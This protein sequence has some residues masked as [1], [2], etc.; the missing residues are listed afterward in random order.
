MKKIFLFVL[1]VSLLLGACTKNISSYNGNLKAPTSVPAGPLFTY[2]ELN[3]NEDLA[4][5]SAYNNIFRHIVE[6]WSQATNEDVAQYN[7]NLY[8]VPDNWWQHL[9][10]NVLSNFH[11]SDSILSLDKTDLPA[12][13]ANERAII[14]VLEVY[15]FN[16]L[17]NSFGNVPY[18]QAL[19][20]NNLTPV[21]DDAKTIQAD[22]LT[23]L[24]TDITNMTPANASFTGTQDLLY[25]GVVSKWVALANSLKIQIAMTLADV[26]NTT[27]QTVMEASNS[28]AFQS[29]ATDAV[30]SAFTTA[31]PDPLYTNLVLSG[32]TDYLACQTLMNYL[33]SMNDPRL[34]TYFAT[35]TSGQYVGSEIGLQQASTGAISKPGAIFYQAT[36]P[37]VFMD[38]MNMEFYR[39][40]AI[41]RGYNI[42]GT[43]EQ[44]YDTAIALSIRYYGGTNA[45]AQ[46]YLAQPDVAYT[47]AG[48]GAWTWRQK[49]GFQKWLAL[50]GRGMDSYTELRRFD[51]PTMV[52][53]VGAISGFPYRMTYPATTVSEQ[54]LNPVN[55]AQAAAAIGGDLVS[56]KLYWDVN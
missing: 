46:A 20:F 35:N 25:G 52:P 53:P 39:A 23:R 13:V 8:N 54:V 6:Y 31:Y 15:T 42:P 48:G 5:C 38:Y 10:V 34:P 11:A 22:L 40:E 19:N 21:F 30:W 37:Y 12:V 43:A 1:P 29:T 56:T 44:H 14:D 51:W 49:I 7:F 33:T 16:T 4:D 32:R 2:A 9:Y 41:E 27:A 45:Q 24:T 3:L 28:A 18:S 26:D 36:C 50:Y 55:Y 17:V 47:T